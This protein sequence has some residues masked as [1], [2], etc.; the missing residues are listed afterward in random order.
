MRSGRSS[1]VNLPNLPMF[2]YDA[3]ITSTELI[4]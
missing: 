1:S 3:S 4:F 2:W